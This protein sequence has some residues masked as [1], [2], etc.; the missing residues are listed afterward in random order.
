MIVPKTSRMARPEGIE[1]VPVEYVHEAIEALQ[2][3]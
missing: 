1:L 2:F 3:E